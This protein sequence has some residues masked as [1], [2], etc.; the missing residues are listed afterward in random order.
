MSSTEQIRQTIKSTQ[1]TRKIT[2]TMKSVALSKLRMTEKAMR[3]S[4]P[5]SREILKLIGHVAQCNSE[6]KHEFMIHRPIVKRVGLIVISSDRGL[7]GGL[8]SN[9]FRRILES[10]QEWK[11]EN[12]DVSLCLMGQKAATFFT[13]LDIEVL[14]HVEHLGEKPSLQDIIG[15]VKIMLDAYLQKNIDAVYIASNEY[16]SIMSQRPRLL[17]LLPIMPSDSNQ[18]KQ[19]HWDY[20]YEPNAGEILDILL[21]RYIESQVYQAVIENIACEMA[22]RM[23]AMDSATKNADEI[24]DDLR[25][26]YNKARQAAIT[27]E[28]AEIVSGADAV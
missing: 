11:A 1:K 22:A 14:G 21:T 20:I 5:Y 16:I 10:T 6:Y 17:Q 9:L 4:K 3:R 19:S 26:Q 2:N 15:V 8:N 23:T 27:Q 7:C 13:G 24:I 28:L 25:L 12:K 18:M